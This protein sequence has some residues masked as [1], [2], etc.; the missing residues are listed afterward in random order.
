ML[1]TLLNRQLKKTGLTQ[2]ESPDQNKW[3][4]FLDKVNK[5]YVESDQERYLL[6]RSLQISSDEMIEVHEELRKSES[7]YAL[8][9]QGANDGLWDWDV[10]TNKVYYSERLF[11]ILG[12]KP[13]PA[14]IPDGKF[15][16]AKIHPQ[17]LEDVVSD[18]KAHLKGLTPRFH[19]EH[20]IMHTDGEYRWI[21]I[22]G[23]AVRNETGRAIRVAGSISDVTERKRTEEKLEHDSVHDALTGL[24]NRKLLLDRLSRSLERMK[25]GDTTYS[26][27]TLF[28]DLDRFKTI[29]DS[30]GHHKGDEFLVKVAEKLNSSVRPSDMVVRLGGD[31]FVVLAENVRD[32]DR[33]VQIAERILAL[34]QSPITLGSEQVF[35]SASIGIV[36]STPDYKK[37]DDLIRDADLAMYRA[38]IKGKSRYEIFDPQMHTGAMSL[39]QME[40]DLRQAIEKKEF[41]LF[42]QPIVSLNTDKVVGFEA[43]LR[44]RHPERGMVPP[45]EFIPVAEETGVIVTIGKWVLQEAC[46]QMK[47]WHDLCP[48]SESLVV[49]VNLSARQL[50]QKHIVEDVFKILN[51][52][53]LN[54]SCLKLEITESVIMS[55]AEAAEERVRTLRDLGVR[56]SIDDFGTGY[57]SLSY[58]HRFP[59]D[60][61]KADR[62]FISRI[63]TSGENSE[64]IKTIISL[65][66]NLGIEVVAEGIETPE[67]LDFLRQ[68]D[69]SYG[70]GYYY[71]RPVNGLAATEMLQVLAEE[72]QDFTLM[73]P[74]IEVDTFGLGIS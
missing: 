42:Y 21:L 26:F 10:A 63:G 18:F 28:I 45:A 52:T 54:P 13:Q 22:R 17:D 16:V 71:S 9:A 59:I 69:C 56:V 68:M 23:L 41:S 25:R 51:E 55:N 58:L 35:T 39:F 61:L 57:S 43:L 34:L 12:M 40:M 49:S 62:S 66:R 44:W 53:G 7:R 32:Q 8:A 30:L 38:K 19:N 24:P 47:Q 60:T 4:E 11:E 70:Q 3:L 50:E 1:H 73:P 67:Q 36:M 20:R 74:A 5:A 65:A 2:N 27:A 6:E 33:V 37:P 46:R 64:I 15:W 72:S 29:N 14:E 31:E 48:S